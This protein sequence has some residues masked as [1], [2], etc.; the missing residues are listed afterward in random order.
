MDSSRLVEYGLA[1][2]LELE[3]EGHI[4]EEVENE[5]EVEDD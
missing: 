2:R 1:R 5:P 4:E 3:G